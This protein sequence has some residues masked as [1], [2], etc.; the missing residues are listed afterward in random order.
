MRNTNR[1]KAQVVTFLSLALAATLAASGCAREVA[2]DFL[3]AFAGSFGETVTVTDSDSTP[4]AVTLEIPDIGSGPIVIGPG[5]PPVTL[6]LSLGQSFFVV[7]VAEDPEGVQ[8]VGFSG[9][10]R[11]ECSSGSGIGSIQFATL[12]G[13]TSTDDASPGETALTRRWQPTLITDSYGC[14]SGST[15]SYRISLIVRGK[16]FSGQERVTNAA[17]FVYSF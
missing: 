3:D 15:G 2:E 6:N 14:G 5:D 9:S 1:R 11:R 4:P 7:G 17:T 13:P 8:S 16:N 12:L 10:S